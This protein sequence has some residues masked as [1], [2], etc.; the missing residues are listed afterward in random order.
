MW[1]SYVSAG[2]PYEKYPLGRREELVQIFA[3]GMENNQV[4]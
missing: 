1:S 2:V 4:T 3:V